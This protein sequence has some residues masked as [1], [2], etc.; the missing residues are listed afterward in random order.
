[1]QD[2][3]I[4]RM[5]RHV[6]RVKVAQRSLSRSLPNRR[7]GQPAQDKPNIP[8]ARATAKSASMARAF[9]SKESKGPPSNDDITDGSRAL[10]TQF[11]PTG[12]D[13]GSYVDG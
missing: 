8:S 11:C 5:N 2:I 1:M 7:H 13:S 3:D 6:I 12:H 4:E 10:L 9:F